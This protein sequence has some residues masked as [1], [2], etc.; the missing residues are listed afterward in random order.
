M[1]T[2]RAYIFE[3]GLSGISDQGAGSAD[4]TLTGENIMYSFGHSVGFGDVDGDGYMDLA[5]STRASQGW[6]YIFE[7]WSSGITDQ[8]LSDGGSADTKLTGEGTDNY[9]GESVSLSDVDGNGYA[10]LAVGAYM[11]NSSQGRVY[12][13]EG[14]SLGIADKNLGDPDYDTADTTL[15]GEESSGFGCSLDG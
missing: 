7:G 8:D 14:G 15:S 5:V 4:T 3:G 13:F 9:F 10:D 11:Y 2:G 6:T 1:G 12:I